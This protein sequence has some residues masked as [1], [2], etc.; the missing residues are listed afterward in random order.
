MYKEDPQG[1]KKIVANTA[2]YPS[3]FKKTLVLNKVE[4]EIFTTLSVATKTKMAMK[5]NDDKEISQ[6]KDPIN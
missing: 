3:I 1:W 4:Y 2:K 5:G 6:Y